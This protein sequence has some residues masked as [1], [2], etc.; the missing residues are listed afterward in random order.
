[1]PDQADGSKKA[2]T[3]PAEPESVSAELVRD[4][5]GDLLGRVTYGREEFI[6]TR[7]GKP[8]ARLIPFEAAAA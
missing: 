6:I 1:M 5:L 7:H 2:P 3:A 8:V 4:I